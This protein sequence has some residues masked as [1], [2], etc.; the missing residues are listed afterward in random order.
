[1]QILLIVSCGVRYSLE[2]HVPM[3]T[4]GTEAHNL[5]YYKPFL[6][7]KPLRHLTKPDF[8]GS[9]ELQRTRPERQVLSKQACGHP[10]KPH[11]AH[12]D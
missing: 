2:S 4:N 9:A 7:G 8:P 12:S 10:A 1:M 3:V 5:L 11:A 6:H